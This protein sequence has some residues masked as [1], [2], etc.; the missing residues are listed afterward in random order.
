MLVKQPC[1][2]SKSALRAS[3]HSSWT[4]AAFALHP[5]WLRERCRDPR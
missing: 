5:I 1:R 3:V 4:T 2:A